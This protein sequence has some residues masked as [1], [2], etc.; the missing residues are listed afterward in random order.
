MAESGLEPRLLHTISHDSTSVLSLAVDEQSGLVFSGSQAE[1][2]YVWDLSTFQ[3]KT[4]LEGHTASVLALELCPEKSWL[5]SASGDST[6]RIW[7]TKTLSPLCVIHPADDRVG[8]IFALKWCS[9]LQ[10]L[11]FGCQNTSLQWITLTSITSAISQDE[12]RAVP[13]VRP[14]KFFDSGPHAGSQTR[15]STS[16]SRS[17]S[18]RSTPAAGWPRGSARGAGFSTPPLDYSPSDRVRRLQVEQ[19]HMV[20]S[21]HSGYIYALDLLQKPD[22]HLDGG[23]Q[24]RGGSK[25][26]LVSGSG[27]E[28]IKLWSCTPDGLTQEAV[29]HHSDNGVLALA[30]WGSCTLFAGLQGGDIEVWDVET[31]RVVR[32]LHAHDDDVLALV[33]VGSIAD[34]D[35]CILYSASA[36]GRIRRWDASFKCTA[37]WVAHNGIVLSIASLPQAVGNQG[38]IVLTGASDDRIKVWDLL[39]SPGTL[40]KH[41]RPT[42]GPSSLGTA[43][44]MISALAQFVAFKSVSANEN[45]REDCR[46]CA[47]WLKNH[48]TDLGAETALLPGA[49]GHN[50][51]VLATFRANKSRLA[52][53]KRVVAYAHYDVITPGP[54][55]SWSNSPWSLTGRDGY[56]HARGV[57]DNKGPCLAIAYA[58]AELAKEGTLGADVTL[59]VEGEEEAGGCGFT[60]AIR[61]AKEQIGPVDV[62]LLSNSY[63]LGE[64]TPCLTVG[65]RGVVQ[66]DLEVRSDFQDRHSGVDGGAVREPMIDMI[67]LLASLTE[68]ERVLLPTFYDSVRPITPAERAMYAQIAQ[69]KHSRAS[70]QTVE[71]LMARWRLPSL[72]VHRISVSSGSGSGNATVIPS[73]VTAAVSLRLVPDQ[74]LDVITDTLIAHVSAHF[75]KLASPNRIGVYIKHR[76]DWW[77]GEDSAYS[78]ALA[79][80]VQSEWGQAPVSI[81]EGGSIPSLAIL[82]KE[83]E[84]P[85][86]HLPMGQASDRAHLADERLRLVNLL[87]GKSV[88][89]RWLA[90][91]AI[92]NASQR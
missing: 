35:T 66:A 71:A 69:M 77:L 33:T 87:K 25:H 47:H 2:I 39:F 83:L 72:S 43:D 40:E 36:D 11:Y 19:R 46:Q 21:A 57:S 42:A 91:S 37:D 49:E 27:D 8:D 34:E 51:L 89:K 85:A 79:S 73:T 55:E 54:C 6:V 75:G 28:D 64:D 5:F 31:G 61:A 48:L 7:D 3:E 17:A 53:R 56:L 44:P 67:K 10:T 82:E 90:S 15:L 32:T 58:A 14:H 16:L 26:M 50:P 12:V 41:S 63:W 30:S 74:D 70:G 45:L 76:A 92:S 38:N 13:I 29:L 18:G 22:R 60:E 62:I 88:V 86:V 59:V 81:R 78:T 80:A 65:L 20:S 24:R 52:P 4:R 1:D 9:E 84:A 68:G 23:G